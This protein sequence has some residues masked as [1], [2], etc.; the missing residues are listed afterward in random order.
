MV[1]FCKG[2]LI[3][4]SIAAPV[5]PIGLLCIRRSISHGRVAGLVTGLGAAS[6]DAVY[7][8]IAAFGLT[9]ITSALLAAQTWLQLGGGIFLI[10][11]GVKTA[12]EQPTESVPG[13]AAMPSR[14]VAYSS[15]FALTLTNP[16]T[17]LSFVAIF[18]GL[19]LQGGAGAGAAS[20]LV[21]GVFTGS[22][23]WWLVLSAAANW[24]GQKL[25]RRR[26]RYVNWTSGVILAALGGWQCTLAVRSLR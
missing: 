17:I 2:L 3:G 22:A 19:G 24:A 15:T 14:F 23:S 9:V 16:M 13:V 8:A 25:S 12:R 1:E 18:A 20:L 26:L 4:C 5:G 6:A 11:I 21:A 7:G 10:G